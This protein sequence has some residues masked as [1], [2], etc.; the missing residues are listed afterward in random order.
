MVIA[1]FN[2]SSY[3][4]STHHADSRALDSMRSISSYR[5]NNSVQYEYSCHAAD[6]RRRRST[7]T[8]ERR[9]DT[10]NQLQDR[11][12]STKPRA[13]VVKSPFKAAAVA[14]IAFALLST[15]ASSGATKLEV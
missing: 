9:C 7:T 4:R 13:I 3:R 1:S 2:P 14:A 12:A 15:S 11:Q 5:R 6:L 10:M 8:N